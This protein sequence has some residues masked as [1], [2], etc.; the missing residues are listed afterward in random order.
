VSALTD[1]APR[2]FVPMREYL[3]LQRRCDELEARLAEQREAERDAAD[4]DTAALV[5]R[6]LNL[7]PQGATVLLTLFAAN[8]P[9]MTACRLN[10]RLRWPSDRQVNVVI[11]R[12]NA[13][14]RRLGAPAYV[15]AGRR[16]YG[17]G[18]FVTDEGRAWLKARV[19]E[20]FADGGKP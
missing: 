2:G 7:S 8:K 19:P 12:A 3:R 11:S 14:M 16:A 13:A 18:L 9:L 1:D 17:G 15:I 5:R 4:D 6:R 10:L 20:A